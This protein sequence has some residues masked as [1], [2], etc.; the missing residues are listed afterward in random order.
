MDSV[1]ETGF[2]NSLILVRNRLAIGSVWFLLPLSF[3]SKQRLR[4]GERNLIQQARLL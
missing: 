3:V 4:L 2:A 1:G